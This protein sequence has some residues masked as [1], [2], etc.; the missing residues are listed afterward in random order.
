M[1]GGVK[2]VLHPSSATRPV[3][4][5]RWSYHAV[6]GVQRG[7]PERHGLSLPPWIAASLRSSQ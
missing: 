7:D 2:L 6:R 4:P 1:L 3:V 5:V